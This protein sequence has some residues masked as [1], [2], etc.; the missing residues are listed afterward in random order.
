MVQW[1]CMQRLE[2]IKKLE[3]VGPRH[4][5]AILL[6]INPASETDNKSLDKL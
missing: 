5:Q 1:H 2:D 6:H 4:C 3:Y